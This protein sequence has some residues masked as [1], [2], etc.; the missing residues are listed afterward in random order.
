[1]ETGS[2]VLRHMEHKKEVFLLSDDEDAHKTYLLK[3]VTRRVPKK[4]NKFKDIKMDHN[5]FDELY[6]KFKPNIS[7]FSV[8]FYNV[9]QELKS[10]GE[11]MLISNP[12]CI[13]CGSRDNA[14]SRLYC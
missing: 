13:M 1:M 8:E 10:C 3:S 12:K 4:I 9:S 2:H 5:A 7:S 14:A 11:I 6:M